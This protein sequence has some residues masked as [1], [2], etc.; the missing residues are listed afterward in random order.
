MPGEVESMETTNTPAPAERSP[1]EA[2]REYSVLLEMIEHAASIAPDGKSPYRNAELLEGLNRAFENG[3]KTGVS[4]VVRLY[5][6]KHPE[7][8]QIIRELE[9]IAEIQQ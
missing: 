5:R 4:E 6:I 1:E 3:V 2:E 7:E 9:E 8:T